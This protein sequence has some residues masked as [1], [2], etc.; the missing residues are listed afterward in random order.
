MPLPPDRTRRRRGRLCRA[1]LAWGLASVVAAG[2]CD[3]L[4]SAK[5]DHPV[6]G[7]PPPRLSWD[8]SPAGSDKVADASGEP[9]GIVKVS[10]TDPAPIG[11]NSV[12]AIVNG[13]PILAGQLLAPFSAYFLQAAAEGRPEWQIEGWK[14][15]AIAKALD[16]KIEETLLVQALRLM[17]KPEQLTQ[18]SE[19]LDEEFKKQNLKMME[20]FKVGSRAELEKLLAERGTSLS[21]YEQ[22]FKNRKMA[23]VY[24]QYKAG[25]STPVFGRQDV[26]DYYQAH[27][28]KFTHPA[29]AKFQLLMVS[30]ATNGGQEK[31]RAKIDAALTELERGERFPEVVKRHSDGPHASEGG[32]HDWF[33]RGEFNAKQVDEALFTLPVGQVSP[34]YETQT[35]RAYMAVKVTG[36]EEEGRT[37]VADVQDEI[38]AALLMESRRETVE[39]LLKHLH[40]TAVITKYVD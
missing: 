26:L 25:E 6:L 21:A 37:P 16:S 40:E 8:D 15:E 22:N 4:K 13:E 23:E 24:I 5:H 9:T 2:G 3:A 14:R 35:P 27:L 34:V 20:Q 28:D 7:P 29:R 30:F 36:R 19:K 10:L 11:D 12:I 32:D 33:K 38:R 18:V 17:L 31:A 39:G 1:G